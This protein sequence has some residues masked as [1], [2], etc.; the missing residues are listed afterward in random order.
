MRTCV[1]MVTTHV[2][3]IVVLLAV[4]TK[5]VV[6]GEPSAA[7]PV[8]DPVLVLVPDPVPSNSTVSYRITCLFSS[9]RCVGRT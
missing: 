3:T 4:D 6:F 5:H 8:P 1:A 9:C 7:V 2:E